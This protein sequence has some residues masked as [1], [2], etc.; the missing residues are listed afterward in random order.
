MEKKINVYAGNY[1]STVEISILLKESNLE[2]VTGV[3]LPKDQSLWRVL[4]QHLTDK[5]SQILD[6]VCK[7]FNE[8]N[9]RLNFK[10]LK[11]TMDLGENTDTQI[12]Q[13]LLADKNILVYVQK[14]KDIVVLQNKSDFGASGSVINTQ[15]GCV[16]TVTIDDK[17]V[18]EELVEPVFNTSEEVVGST[19]T[20][21][22]PLDREEEDVAVEPP[23]AQHQTPNE[24]FFS[25]EL[26]VCQN[27]TETDDVLIDFDVD[28]VNKL[29]LSNAAVWQRYSINGTNALW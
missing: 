3:K 20:Q 6:S 14:L 5:Y 27:T 29:I 23:P 18:F 28:K 15:H 19:P 10:F 22:E 11:W 12:P 8:T 13:E 25:L 9:P 26:V 21:P 7:E 24:G 2:G 16:L 17:V 1:S 4:L